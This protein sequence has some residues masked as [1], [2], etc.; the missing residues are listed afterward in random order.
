[1]KELFSKE[2]KKIELNILINFDEFCRKN[3]LRYYLSGGT[4]LGAIRHKGFIPWDD[5]I[6]VCMPRPDFEKLIELFP[7]KYKDIYV[8]KSV[9][10]NNFQYPFIKIVNCKTKINCKYVDNK[11]ENNLWMDI[12]P[13]DG[14]PK[15]KSKLDKIYNEVKFYR[16]LLILNFAKYNQGKNLLK[17]ILK[18]FLIFVAR[19]IGVS[20]CLKKIEEIASRYDYAKSDYVGAITWGLY[21][22]GERMKKSEFEKVVYVDFEGYRFPTFS[23]WD[24]YLKGLYKDYM[25]IP[26]PKDRKTHDMKVYILE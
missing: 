20:F 17:K 9:K 4:L 16:K 26:A 21:G 10:K 3:K 8:L 12:F 23:C 22:V 11:F 18:P 1:M 15:D 6:D 5:D 2:V 14:L 25:I 24:S 19:L 13:V 7:D